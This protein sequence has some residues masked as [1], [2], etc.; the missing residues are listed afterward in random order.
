MKNGPGMVH[1]VVFPRWGVIGRVDDGR[2]VES[3]W[4]DE[5]LSGWGMQVLPV[6]IRKSIVLIRLPVMMPRRE[7]EAE[8]V[9]VLSTSEGQSE[10]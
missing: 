10:R 7:E 2:V 8:D 4:E 3:V 1:F 5:L 9:H 6:A